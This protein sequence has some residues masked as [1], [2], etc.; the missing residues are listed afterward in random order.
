MKKIFYIIIVITFFISSDIYSQYPNIL[1]DGNGSPEEVAIAINPLNPDILAAGA[2]IDNFYRSINGGLTWTE[3]NLV[4]N[5][6]G[7]WGDP[8]VLFDSLGNLYYAHLSNPISGWWIDRIVV[9]KSTNS[10]LTW[11]D[12]VGIGQGIQPQAQDKPWLAVD[13][14]QSPYRGNL[15]VTWT[16]FDDYGTSNPS[17]SSRIKFSKSTDQGETWSTAI[18]ISDVSGDCVDSDNTDE[19]AVPCVGPNGEI[20]VAWAGPVG[21]VFD[22]STDGG[23]TWGTDIFVSDI[24]GGWDFDVSGINR[25]NGLPITMCDIGNSPY[26]GYIYV[27]WSDQRNGATDTDIFMS[28]STNGGTTWSSA[29]KVNDD[30][31]TRQQ[32]FV[33]S[34]IDYSTGHLWFVFYDRRNTTGAATDVFVAKSIDGGTTFENFKVSE[35]SFTPTSNVFFGDYTNIAALN[36]KIYPF[37]MRLQGSLSVLITIIEDSITVPVELNNFVANA[38]DGKVYL[39][40]ET[41]TEINNSGFYIE[42]RNTYSGVNENDWVEIGFEEGKG[43]STER[44]FYSFEDHP[45]YDGTYHYR[46]RQVDYDGSFKYSNEIEVNLFSVKSFELSQNYPNPFNPST[47]ISFQLPEESFISLKVYDAIGTEVETIAE[48][49]YPAGVHEVIFNADNLSSGL[50]LYRITSGKNE[51]TRKMLV[52]K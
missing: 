41:A 5:N 40:W 21:L 10:G 43:N 31:T 19:G 36:G 51:L 39:T 15:Y 23:Q 45:L 50:Y 48:G 8:V 25:C 13:H 35:S 42:R 34:T 28:R 26:N 24:P 3:T 29:I 27:V 17:D 6:L 4:S 38:N 33:W 37:W 11:N 30:N 32:F 2:N 18:T 16:E 7:V 14:T 9:Q 47:T 44:N 22:K 20:Y 46:L 1:V 52:V 49:E 12:G